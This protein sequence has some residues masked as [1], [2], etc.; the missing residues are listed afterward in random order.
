MSKSHIYIRN[1][2]DILKIRYLGPVFRK[3]HKGRAKT[4]FKEN[5]FQ[6]NSERTASD[7]KL[8]GKTRVQ[9]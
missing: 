7:I 1:I 5:V 2:P 6:L 3:K 4:N 8:A 9:A